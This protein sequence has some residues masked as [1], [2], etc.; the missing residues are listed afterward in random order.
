MQQ[1][2]HIHGGDTFL[3]E[4]S[5]L[6]Y[7]QQKSYNPF[8]G[9]KWRRDWIKAK[10]PTPPYEVGL[11]DMPSPKQATYVARKIR[12]EK[13]F[14]YLNDEG[15]ILIGESLGGAFLLKYLTESTF[16]RPIQQLHLVATVIDKSGFVFD[17]LKISTLSDSIEKIFI[18]H[19]IDDPSVP[20]S[21]GERL[22]KFL[23]TAEFLT[24]S[25]RGHFS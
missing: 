21:H 25:D 4:I 16:P 18:Y 17:L 11:L 8:R 9:N 6:A 22:S 10:L 14:P 5:F 15:T 13:V 23:P 1:V 20:Y 12:F 3:D 19:S 7:L 2:I 24:F